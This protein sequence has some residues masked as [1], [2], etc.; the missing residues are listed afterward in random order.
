MQMELYLI[1]N[2]IYNNK[3]KISFSLTVCKFLKLEIELKGFK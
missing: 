2:N 1:L 3:E